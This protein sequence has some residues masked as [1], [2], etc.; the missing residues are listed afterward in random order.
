MDRYSKIDC[1]ICGKPLSNTDVVVCP[2][3]GA[4]YH[5]DCFVNEG[6]NCVF[7]DLH[8]KNE[9]WL[10]PVKESPEA[11]FDGNAELRCS[12]CGTINPPNGLFCQVCGNQLNDTAP[13][14]EGNNETATRQQPPQTLG[15]MGGFPPGMPLNPFTTPFGG[16]AP[17]EVIDEVPA[18]D[19]A[20]FVGR[21]SHYY[22]PAF[23]A[24]SNKKA[25]LINWS[26]FFFQGGFLLYRKMYVL[27]IIVFLLTTILSMPYALLLYQTMNINTELSLNIPISI[28]TLTTLNLVCNFLGLVLRFTLGLFANTLYKSSVYSKIKSIKNFDLPETEYFATLTKKGSVALKL[29]TGLL[30]GFMVLYIFTMGSA[31]MLGL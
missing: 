16:V 20:I 3:C 19:L 17:D 1:P 8:E 21:N 26:A 29:V 31:L 12:R 7:T 22:L 25:K 27:G 6:G 11:K 10:A 4:P 2:I 13:N 18:K 30:I 23:K 9:E 14:T 5:R 24:I 28:E 15:G